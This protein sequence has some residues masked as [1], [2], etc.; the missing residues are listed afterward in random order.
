MDAVQLRKL[1]GWILFNV[2]VA[3][4]DIAANGIQAVNGVQDIQLGNVCIGPEPEVLCEASGLGGV[5]TQ[6]QNIVS[7]YD[8]GYEAT[9][10]IPGKVYFGR[11]RGPEDRSVHVQKGTIN[12]NV[13][14]GDMDLVKE[15]GYIDMLVS[16]GVKHMHSS[17]DRT[18]CES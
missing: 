6:P 1:A 8:M 4:V 11:G 17:T 15:G 10:A 3:P 12:F 2:V 9:N 18:L 16:L 14:K 5:F 13:A 7:T